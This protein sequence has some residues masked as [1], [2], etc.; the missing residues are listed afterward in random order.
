MVED[1]HVEWIKSEGARLFQGLAAM[2]CP[3]CGQPVGF[4]Q[5]KISPAPAGVPLVR[6]NAAK[7]AEWAAS[8]AVSA[9]G[10]LRGYLSTAGAGFQYASFSTPPSVRLLLECTG[11]PPGWRKWAGK[12][13]GAL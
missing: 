10:T 3:V 4:R 6:R 9:G 7:A 8:Q 13:T 1:W 11:S 2:D 5:G 12:E